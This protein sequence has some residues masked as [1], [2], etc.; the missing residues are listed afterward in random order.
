[1]AVDKV[2][3]LEAVRAFRSLRSNNATEDDRRQAR[4]QLVRIALNIDATNR[5]D[6]IDLVDQARA[7]PDSQA[8]VPLTEILLLLGRERRSS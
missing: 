6:L 4:D 5:S 7:A 1:M 8:D 3:I 2:Q